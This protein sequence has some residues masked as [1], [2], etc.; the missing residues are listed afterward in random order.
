[1]KSPLLAEVDRVARA[2]AALPSAKELAAVHHVTPRYVRRLLRKATDE[3]RLFLFGT[4]QKDKL[5]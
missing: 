2:R 4:L 1:M 3:A 5:E